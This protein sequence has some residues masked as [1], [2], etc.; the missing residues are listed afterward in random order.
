V[1]ALVRNY[2]I[3]TKPH[4]RILMNP[5]EWCL[6][7]RN[8]FLFISMFAHPHVDGYLVLDWD[9]LDESKLPVDLIRRDGEKYSFILPILLNGNTVNEESS[10]GGLD[11]QAFTSEAKHGFSGAF[12]DIDLV[13]LP[14]RICDGDLPDKRPV[15]GISIHNV[16]GDCSSANVEVARESGE[17]KS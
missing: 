3:M 15:E 5:S 17:K 11:M 10:S 2:I 14:G 12:P 4:K 7:Y 16:G 13:S 6:T 9:I 8:G 1:D